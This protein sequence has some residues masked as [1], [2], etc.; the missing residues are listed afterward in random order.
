MHNRFLKRLDRPAAGAGWW[1]VM[2]A[3]ILNGS[4]EA[5][6]A[7]DRVCASLDDALVSAG[8]EA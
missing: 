2:E 3:L 6:D 8:W 1:P 5:G 7:T 4:R